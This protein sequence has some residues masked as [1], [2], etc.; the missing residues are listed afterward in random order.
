MRERTARDDTKNGYI[1]DGYP[2]TPVQ[3]ETSSNWAEQGFEIKA[4]ILIDVP[5]EELEEANYRPPNVSGLW[6]DL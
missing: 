5:R 1:L 3:A 6:R 2:R 4:H